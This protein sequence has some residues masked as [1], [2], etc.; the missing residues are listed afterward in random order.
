MSVGVRHRSFCSPGNRY[1]CADDFFAGLLV[2]HCFRYGFCLGKALDNRQETKHHPNE[3]HSD[4][5]ISFF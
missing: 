3:I 2:G 4:Q 5:S 1:A